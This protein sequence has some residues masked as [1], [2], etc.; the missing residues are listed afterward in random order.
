MKRDTEHGARFL[1]GR[2]CMLQGDVPSSGAGDEKGSPSLIGR[3]RES[4]RHWL[5][6]QLMALFP[7]TAATNSH[8]LDALRHINV[9]SL[10]SGG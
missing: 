8:Q 6:L 4:Q 9:L 7:E 2:M 10:G 5:L 3:F 1:V